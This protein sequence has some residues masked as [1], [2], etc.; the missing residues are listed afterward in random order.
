MK[1]FYSFLTKKKG[2]CFKGFYCPK[3]HCKNA[4]E[5]TQR[6]FFFEYEMKIATERLKID[7]NLQELM[8]K[9]KNQEIS[10]IIS[11][12]EI[13][14]ETNEIIFQQTLDNFSDKR[15]TL[16]DDRKMIAAEYKRIKEIEGKK[17]KL[18]YENQLKKSI[19]SNIEK[20]QKLKDPSSILEDLDDIFD[21]SNV[22]IDSTNSIQVKL[23]PDPLNLLKKKETIKK[24]PTPVKVKKRGLKN[25]YIQ[26]R[27][28]HYKDYENVKLEK[29]RIPLNMHYHIPRDLRQK[30]LE[31]IFEKYS[32]VFEDKRKSAI[33]ALET[34]L[35]INGSHPT[36][37]GYWSKVKEVVK[38]IELED[39]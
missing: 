7:K 24:S 28:I 9:P 13:K 20:K 21:H 25:P 26:E 27:D 39:E 22:I 10:E 12:L 19:P 29:P 31:M 2:F 5:I 30:S 38:G 33:F 14:T 15:P 37:H 18:E 3:E 34:E 4:L 1:Y 23:N 36:Q 32:T 35:K 8:N 11:N 6:M 16:E 17:R